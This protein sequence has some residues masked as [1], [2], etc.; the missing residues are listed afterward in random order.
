MGSTL[1]DGARVET[2]ANG[3][4]SG[5]PGRGRDA[6]A[7]SVGRERAGVASRSPL[8]D[9]GAVKGPRWVRW[10]GRGKAGPGAGGTA[11]VRCATAAAAT[12]RDS[13][14]TAAASGGPGAAGGVAAGGVA[15]GGV[16]AAGGVAGRGGAA[17]TAATLG[18]NGTRTGSSFA[19]VS[20]SCSAKPG[21]SR[22]PVIMLVAP[23]R[24][25]ASSFS[26]VKKSVGWL[27]QGRAQ[28]RNST[29]CECSISI[30]APRPTS[31][32]N[33]ACTTCP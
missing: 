5:P 31:S 32:P 16:T 7:G 6:G 24:V 10:A 22:S 29:G 20:S 1:D 21:L 17:R 12:A 28:G 26:A 14:S 23:G 13:S 8:D 3:S 4:R 25:A 11:D 19:C 2:G 30:T 9:G 15:A 18:C 27:G 33:S